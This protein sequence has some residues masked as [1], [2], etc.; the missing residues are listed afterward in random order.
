[1]DDTENTGT[2]RT[3]EKRTKRQT[4]VWA[5]AQLLPDPT[6]EP[7]YVFR[8]VRIST[9]GLD[10]AMNI[11]TRLR[12]GYEPVKATDHPE[13]QVAGSPE[14]RFKDCIVIGGLMLCKIPQELADQRDDYYRDQAKQQL[15]AVD[16][17][18]MRQSD[19]RMPL[20]KERKTE[21]VVGKGRS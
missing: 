7:G 16:S 17:N 21:V 15:Q 12:E 6:P 14:G 19:S 5:P 4:R 8:W 13:V 11:S 18:L 1:M 3:R 10:D 20:F 9:L 2:E